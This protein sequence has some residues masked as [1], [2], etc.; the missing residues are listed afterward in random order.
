M[1]KDYYNF[2]KND[3][4]VRWV[5]DRETSVWKRESTPQYADRYLRRYLL[6]WMVLIGLVFILFLFFANIPFTKRLR[7]QLFDQPLLFL[8]WF[9]YVLMMI[10]TGIFMKK[11]F[12]ALIEATVLSALAFFTSDMLLLNYDTPLYVYIGTGFLVSLLFLLVSL[13]VRFLL[14]RKPEDYINKKEKKHQRMS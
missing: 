1:F 13:F 9:I 2:K 14:R 3:K 4:R 10:L 6:L 11:F 7:L 5:Y 12:R 8:D